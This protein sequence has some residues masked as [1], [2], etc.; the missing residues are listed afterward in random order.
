MCSLRTWTVVRYKKKAD[1]RIVEDVF[2]TDDDKLAASFKTD[3]I[4]MYPN[5]I[6]KVEYRG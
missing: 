2:S 3:W 4:K 1:K 6:V 5:S